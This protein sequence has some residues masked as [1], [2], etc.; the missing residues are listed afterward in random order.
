MKM[1]LKH[2]NLIFRK[3]LTILYYK[4]LPPPCFACK[5]FLNTIGDLKK[6]IAAQTGTRPEKIILKKWYTVYKDHITLDDYEIHDGFNFELAP[7]N[8]AMKE[9]EKFGEDVEVGFEMSPT[10]ATYWFRIT[11]TIPND[12]IGEKV[13][14]SWDSG[15]EVLVWNSNGT[16]SQG[17]SGDAGR[18]LYVLS[19]KV[20]PDQLEY[21]FYVEV[22][23]NTMFGAGSD[24]TIA[25]PNA[26]RKFFIKKAEIVVINEEAFQLY[27]DFDVLN[28]MIS[29][30]PADS[31]DRYKALYTANMMVNMASD[32][33]K[34]SIMKAHALAVGFFCN[35]ENCP[36]NFTVQAVGNCHIDT[37]WLWPYAE[38]KRKCARAWSS[39]LRLMEE[40][41]DLTFACSQALQMRWVQ[42]FYPDLF[43]Q[44][45][46]R[47]HEGRFVLVGGAWV[48]HDGCLPSG[49]SFVRQLLYGQSYFKENFG[50]TCTEAWLPDTFGYSGQLP[51]IFASA[52]MRRFVT[53]KLSW[54]VVNKFPNSTFLWEGIDGTSVVAHLPPGNSY[55]MENT[56]SDVFKTMANFQD[57]GRSETALLLFG[58]GD[59]GGGPEREMCERLVR[60]QRLPGCPAVKPT[61]PASFFEDVEATDMQNLLTWVG[62]LYLEMHNGTYTTQA[63]VKR[64]NRK[65]EFL[66]RD[67]EM[68]A[69]MRFV[70]DSGGDVRSFYKE[71]LQL[72]Q[73]QFHDVLPGTCIALAYVEANRMYQKLTSE[74]ENYLDESADGEFLMNTLGW[75]RRLITET[76]AYLVPAFSVIRKRDAVCKIDD[77]VHVEQIDELIVMKNKFVEIA[78]DD[79]GR[80]VRLNLPDHC[81]VIA[82]GMPGN[83]FTMFD[84]VPL[85]WDAWDVMDY[86]LETKRLLTNVTEGPTFGISENGLT[87]WVEFTLQISESSNLKQRI[88]L[89]AHCPYVQFDSSVIWMEK[90]KFMKV[91]FPLN[92]RS[93]EATYEIQF[94]HLSRPTHR[95]TSW[96]SAR[97]EVP[98]Q[99][100][101]DLSMYGSGMS[102]LNDCK[103]GYSCYKNILVLS[104]LRSPKRPDPDADIG[105][106]KFSYA[107]MPHCGQF[108]RAVHPDTVNVIQASYE[109]N[110][111]IRV[112]KAPFVENSTVWDRQFSLLNIENPAVIL[113]AV[114][115]SESGDR[116]LL[117]FYES[118]GGQ[119]ETTITPLAF[120]VKSCFTCN[121][122]E[123]PDKPVPLNHSG[124]FQLQFGPF[125]IV[126]I[127]I[128]I[129]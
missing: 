40:Y 41:P 67:C 116:L 5:L 126:S 37:A 81:N 63:E 77:R 73:N 83:Q 53:Q 16:V 11:C 13:C 99:K 23:C 93:L 44:I 90:H 32:M 112:L 98:A 105:G 46:K 34:E 54:N 128:E 102:L 18:T 122:L 85:Y 72:L 26:F 68:L 9:I 28:S 38:T 118:F 51:Q 106:H 2:L 79:R 4:A 121:S 49:E 1:R 115:V 42:K 111:P 14:F 86:H 15:S 12:W 120:G 27:M 75:S 110:C 35:K 108:Q 59:G 69:A 29:S 109:L 22:A 100:W 55:V 19:N 107:I 8:E 84:D 74:C 45:V 56:V 70:L 62:E 96:D 117:R 60:S 36:L 65:G 123:I 17:L 47:V 82:D 129:I 58:K 71:W 21:I 57:K 66:L 91:Q 31:P 101:A 119:A 33:N 94:G 61:T 39:T 125:Q 113:E 127:L 48:E 24:D 89:Q 114:K 20:E 6:L 124:T 95:N 3:W 97:Y 103:Y 30:M 104:L 43:A 87:A 92:V 52:G 88:V 10:W 78:I 50:V 25:P 80:V 76:D 64:K 7:F